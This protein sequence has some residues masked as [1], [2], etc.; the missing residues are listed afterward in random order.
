LQ[1]RQLQA[2]G[3][4]LTPIDE[5]TVGARWTSRKAHQRYTGVVL[6]ERGALRLI[7]SVSILEKS[8]AVEFPREVL[9]RMDRPEVH[10]RRRG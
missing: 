6:Q 7:V 9:P 1:I 2:S 4:V 8:V 10:E 5:I 3:A